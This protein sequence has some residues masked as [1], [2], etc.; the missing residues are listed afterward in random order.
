M[1]NY[2]RAIWPGGTFFLTLVTHNR[3]PILTSPLARPILRNAW[4]QTKQRMPFQTDAVCLLPDHL[5]CLITLPE[6]DSNFSQRIQMIKGIFSIQYLK[7]GGN[8]GKRNQS[9]IKKGEAGIWQ[10]R[11]W[12]HMIRDEDDMQRHFDYIH[13]NPIKHGLTEDVKAWPW[14]SFHKYVR[15]GFYP[16]NWCGSVNI[17]NDREY[18]E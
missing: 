10:R 17:I 15:L 11:F 7:S 3:R 14:S 4:M 13:Y 1:S 9:R 8:D 5:H 12:E 2:R 16:L 18:G 6:N